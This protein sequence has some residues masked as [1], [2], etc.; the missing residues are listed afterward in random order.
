MNKE[1]LMV[2][3]KR[4]GY[5]KSPE[6]IAAFEKT[7]REKFIPEGLSHMAHEDTPIPIGYYQTISAPHMYAIMLELAEI[8][9][10]EKVLEVGTG[11]GYGAALIS[12]LV[13]QKT[14]VDSIEIIPELAEVA[15]QNLA[16]SKIKNVKVIVGNGNLGLA[17][18][19]PFDKIIVTAGA[20]EIPKELVRQLKEGGK[21]VI[22]VGTP[23]FQELLV[24]VKR[25]GKIEYTTHGE[26]IF[27]PLVKKE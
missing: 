26:V 25:N 22:P 18:E 5:L 12:K 21:I 19:A 20:P 1:Q 8:K 2:H 23:A 16:H 6:V 24:G 3:L 4:S 11:S 15:K 17:A 9:K 14:Y 10:G 13:G 27:V 7:P